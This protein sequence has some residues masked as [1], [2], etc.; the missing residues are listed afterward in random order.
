MR[1]KCFIVGG[2]LLS[3]ALAFSGCKGKE[4][5]QPTI[6]TK[7]NAKEAYELTEAE[8]GT[9]QKTKIIVANYQ[10]V[11]S[12]NLSFKADGRRLSGVYVSLGDEVKAGDLLA[13]LFCDEEKARLETYGYELTTGKKELQHLEDQKLFKLDGLAD[14]KNS[15]SAAEY[16]A[17][18]DKIEEEYRLKIEDLEDIIY[19]KQLQYDNL[20]Q[21]VEGCRIYASMDGTVT[22]LGDTGGSFVS[23]GGNKLITVSDSKECAFQCTDTDYFSYFEVG[24]NYVFTT[25]GGAE[26]ETKLTE[27][28]S[29]HGVMRF[30][31]VRSQYG[32]TLGTRVLYS[33]V[34]EEKENVLSIPKAAVH[35]MGDRNFVYYF[36]ENGDRRTKDVTIGMEADSRVEIVSGLAEGDEVILR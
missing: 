29:A 2:V 33:L 35:T 22:Y 10:Q 7:G 28:D 5:E 36:D 14:R 34:L 31:L 15:M 25:S 19:I 4:E 3:C 16:T 26:Y 18:K 8:R 27:I 1:R 21:F 24:K 23:W 9:I 11:K 13:E 32:M 6:M 20:Y 30:E 12:E 17:Q